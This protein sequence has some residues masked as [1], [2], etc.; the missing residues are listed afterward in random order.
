MLRYDGIY[1]YY[2]FCLLRYPYGRATVES[3]GD[4]KAFH[5][6]KHIFV[7]HRPL[8]KTFNAPQ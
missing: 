2:Y 8:G 6:K 3:I 5:V 7:R 4:T 1:Y